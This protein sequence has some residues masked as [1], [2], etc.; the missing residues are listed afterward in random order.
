MDGGNTPD[1][2]SDCL[3]VLWLLLRINLI[4]VVCRHKQG[5]ICIL[6]CGAPAKQMFD[7]S[8]SQAHE[9]EKFNVWKSVQFAKSTTYV[10]K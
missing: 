10:D 6:G 7:L 4:F 3:I 2:S 8:T 1:V 5:S 9:N